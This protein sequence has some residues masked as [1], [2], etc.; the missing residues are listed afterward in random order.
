MNLCFDWRINAVAI[1]AAMAREV[2]I[3]RVLL[4]YKVSASVIAID[5]TLKDVVTVIQADEAHHRDVNTFLVEVSGLNHANVEVVMSKGIWTG[6]VGCEEIDSC[7]IAD[8]CYCLRLGAIAPLVPLILTYT[9]MSHDSFNHDHTKRGKSEPRKKK[10]G[11][12]VIAA[13]ILG[14]R[15]KK[16]GTAGRE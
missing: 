12:G 14:S 13:G 16:I 10:T 3:N 2:A 6:F 5:A 7:Q 11:K 4:C 1:S 15:F 8:C 9:Y